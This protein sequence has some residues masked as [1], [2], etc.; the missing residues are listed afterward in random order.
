[1]IDL[2]FQVS[3]QLFFCLLFS[4]SLPFLTAFFCSTIPKFGFGPLSENAKIA[5]IETE[6]ECRPC[7]L[8]GLMKCP[9][10]HFN[11]AMKI[12]MAKHAV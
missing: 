6:L 7:G 10:G 12:E 11:C 8:H 2:F 1:M 4:F 9:K 3:H 5:Q